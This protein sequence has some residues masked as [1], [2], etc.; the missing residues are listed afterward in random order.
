VPRHEWKSSKSQY[1]RVVSSK[2]AIGWAGSIV[3]NFGDYAH[4]DVG[5][6][7]RLFTQP[8]GLH[9]IYGTMASAAQPL[10]E[11]DIVE[12]AGCLASLK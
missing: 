2:S 9:D 8:T 7:I 6:T 10:S 5:Q 1:W 12:I 3:P 11:K 4:T